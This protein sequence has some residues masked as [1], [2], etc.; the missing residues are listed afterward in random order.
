[1]V[2]AFLKQFRKIAVN[3]SAY[4]TCYQSVHRTEALSRARAAVVANYLWEQ[5]IDTRLLIVAGMGAKHPI[6]TCGPRGDKSL[7]SRVE[8]TFRDA[9]A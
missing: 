7:N 1:M 3:V 2:I 8:I 9:V 6:A 5:G 4:V